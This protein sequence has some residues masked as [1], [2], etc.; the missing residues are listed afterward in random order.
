MYSASITV[1]I[2][3]QKHKFDAIKN[4]ILLSETRKKENTSNY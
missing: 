3:T 4:R 1:I 2:F